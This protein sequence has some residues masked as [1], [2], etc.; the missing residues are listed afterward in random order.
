MAEWEFG[1]RNPRNKVPYTPSYGYKK[2]ST[3]VDNMY[4]TLPDPLMQ[5][6]VVL[7]LSTS[8][9][10]EALVDID[11]I[12]TPIYKLIEDGLLGLE[13]GN[14][15]SFDDDPLWTD[16]YYYTNPAEDRNSVMAWNHKTM[17]ID[18]EIKCVGIN[19][20]SADRACLTDK[21]YVRTQNVNSFD[22]IDAR[23]GRW[24]KS[25]PLPFHPRACGDPHL[26][27]HLQLISGKD[28]P[29]IAVIDTISDT[30]LYVDWYDKGDQSPGGNQGG[31][32]TGHSGWL[33]DEYFFM[34][35]RIADQIR[36]YRITGTIGDFHIRFSHS[37]NVP[38]A[39]HT[40]QDDGVSFELGVNKW[41]GAI[42]GFEAAGI[43]PGIQELNY[44][45]DGNLQL[46]R[47]ATLP[48]DASDTIHHYGVTPG[49]DYIYVPTLVSRRTY[50]LKLETMQYTRYYSSGWGGGHVNFSKQLGRACVTNHFDNFVTIIDSNTHETWNV[51]INN[52]TPGYPGEHLLQTHTNHVSE[53]G[54]W[55]FLG[56]SKSGE[57][58][59]VDIKYPSVHK[60]IYCGGEPE[61]S[62]S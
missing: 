34:L 18:K 24:I 54:R 44:Y 47:L 17:T 55:F 4:S 15:S 48:T 25:V 13:F 7:V 59:Q 58:V 28:N 39:M 61:Q 9:I 37:I 29:G 35:D 57:L 23:Q 22:V 41:Y 19:P 11:D 26:E 38:T 16:Y 3:Q 1:K 12:E 27:H 2:G 62:T 50:V 31:N 40:M 43:V 52:D 20:H 21:M 32:A 49:K 36:I 33:D 6:C 45:G 46:G 5:G 10:Y 42:E 51:R 53:D 8:K 30:V 14:C 56:N 60:K